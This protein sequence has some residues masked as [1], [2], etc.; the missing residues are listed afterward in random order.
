MIGVTGVLKN[1]SVKGVTSTYVTGVLWWV[2]GVI[3]S[4]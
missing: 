1:D 4:S 3:G 2:S